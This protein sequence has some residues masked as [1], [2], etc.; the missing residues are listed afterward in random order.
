VVEKLK[1]LRVEEVEG[2]RVLSTEYLVRREQYSVLCTR[3][4]VPGT[5]SQPA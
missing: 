3:Y 4:S 1:G 5:L 2:S